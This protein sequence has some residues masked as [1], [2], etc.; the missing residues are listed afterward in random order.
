[1]SNGRAVTG[2]GPDNRQAE[3]H[4][5]RPTESK[6]LQRDVSLVVIH[7]D[8]PVKLGIGRPSEQRVSRKRAGRLQ[9]RIGSRLDGRFN[10]S[11]LFITEQPLLPGMRVEGA[12]ADSRLGT[13]RSIAES[14]PRVESSR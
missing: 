13:T 2:G 4:I 11:L 8:D 7:G 6:Q 10:D 14:G 5:H 1:M 12:D 3:R 9:S